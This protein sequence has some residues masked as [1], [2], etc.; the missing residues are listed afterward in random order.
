MEK[1]VVLLGAQDLNRQLLSRVLAQELGVACRIARN[2]EL[3]PAESR[4]TV[5][6]IDNSDSHAGEFLADVKVQQRLEYPSLVLALYNVERPGQ[7]ERE[8]LLRGVKG[9]FYRG[10]CVELLCRGINALFNGETWLSREILVD[11]ATKNH[12]D[13][14]QPDG[15]ENSG[16]TRREAEILARVAI[17]WTNDEIA[18]RMHISTHTVK[19]HLYRVY[20]KIQVDNRFQ[21]SLWAAKNL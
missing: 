13:R 14:S 7:I 8:A 1:C 15:V 12:A 11:L 2:L 10:D 19:T 20:K 6:L 18:V 5:A 9:F 3:V 16:L 17:G 4:H 21:A